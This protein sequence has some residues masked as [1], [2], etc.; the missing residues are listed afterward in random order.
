[1]LSSHSDTVPDGGAWNSQRLVGIINGALVVGV[2]TSFA[3][4]V[5]GELYFSTQW[6]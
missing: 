4:L 1:M 2:L 3:L 5:V 6:S